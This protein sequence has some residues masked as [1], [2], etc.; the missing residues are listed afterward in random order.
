MKIIMFIKGE[1]VSHHE[2]PDE[3]IAFVQGLSGEENHT[4]RQKIIFLYI[5]QIKADHHRLLSKVKTVRFA[6]QF[7]SSMNYMEDHQIEQ[8]FQMNDSDLID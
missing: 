1:A 8:L 6:M 7:E 3:M 4:T 5:E 2:V